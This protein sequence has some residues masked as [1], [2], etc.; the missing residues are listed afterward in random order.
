MIPNNQCR[1]IHAT[2]ATVLVLD[3]EVLSKYCQL[4]TEQTNKLGSNSAAFAA[5]YEN[6]KPQRCSNFTGSSNA[7]EVECDKRLWSRSLERHNMRYVSMLGDGD[8]KAYAAVVKL[9]PYDDNGIER[10]ECVNHAHKR[11]G[12][13]LRRLTKA[14]KLGGRGHGRLMETKTNNFQRYY[15]IAISKNLGNPDAMKDAV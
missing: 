1:S 6:H 7:M 15:N 5:W 8:C 2:H 4:C 9:K 13:A 12:V 14:E 11:M 3:Y 10:E